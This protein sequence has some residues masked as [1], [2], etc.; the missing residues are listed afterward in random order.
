MALNFTNEEKLHKF[1]HKFYSGCGNFLENKFSDRYQSNERHFM[2]LVLK[3]LN[4]GSF[5]KPRNHRYDVKNKERI[6][7]V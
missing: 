6:R 4:Y 5:A 1:S 7:A 3:L 2:D